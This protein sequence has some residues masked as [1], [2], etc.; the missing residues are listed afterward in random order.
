MEEY[1]YFV[2]SA[3]MKKYDR[4]TIEYFGLPSLVL[5]ERAA[6]A[7]T[8]QIEER[9]SK[10]SRVLIA[11]GCGNNGGDGIA[12][13]RMLKLHGFSVDFALIGN[14]QKCSTETE[15][16]I[17]VAEKYGCLI[18]SKI[19]EREYDIVIDALFGIGLSREPKGIF[20]EAICRINAGSGF[21]CA[22]DISSGVNADNGK[23][24]KLAVKADMTVTFGFEKLGHILYPGSEYTGTLICADIGIGTESFLGEGAQIYSFSEQYRRE[25]Q[26][27]L[28]IRK[29]WGNK[30]T[31]G[32]V[33][34][35]AGS[36]NMSGACELC[37]KSAYRIG[38]GMVKVMTSEENRE[39]IQRNVPEALL[40][41]YEEETG[42][43]Q[44][45]L[46]ADM[47]W[48]DCVVIGPGIGKGRNAQSCLETVLR[49]SSLPLVIDADAINLLAESEEL[50]GCLRTQTDRQVILTPHIGEFARLYGCSPSEVKE[51][52]FQKTKELADR[53]HCVVVCKDA[54]TVVA[55]PTK[56]A[57][58]LNT[59]GN[60]GMATAGTGDVLAGM[61]GGLLAQGMLQDAAARSGVYLH[62]IL[63]EQA[64]KRLGRYAVMAGDLVEQLTYIASNEGTNRDD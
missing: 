15:H 64:A 6:L 9:F 29:S 31:F 13:G 57:L 2:S 30:G 38:A 51:A 47:E 44:E 63:G 20:A 18:Q 55:Q 28:P 42:P 52:P 61:L 24:E 37:A 21:V 10:T 39:I 16:Q 53:L 1:R 14:R 50:C 3:E 45:E 23:I 58:F 5:M 19:P 8:E 25:P 43:S 36:K 34:V 33:L 22:V 17:Q 32:K 26:R 4:A 12:I 40:S 46:K 56:A 60:D 54:R 11:A 62:G 41:A 48:A 7:I 49:C 35:I 59:T 27:L